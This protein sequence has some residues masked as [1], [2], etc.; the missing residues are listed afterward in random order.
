[1]IGFDNFQNLIPLFSRGPLCLS[2]SV[3]GEFVSR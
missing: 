2:L 3:F 1:M